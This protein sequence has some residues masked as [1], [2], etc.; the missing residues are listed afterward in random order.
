MALH[1]HNSGINFS[2]R[3]DDYV[4]AWLVSEREDLSRENIFPEVSGY[5]VK[6][7]YASRLANSRWQVN[8]KMPPGLSQG[9]HNLSIR[10]ADS[11]WSNEVRLAVDVPAHAESLHVHRACD[12][13][14]WVDGEVT[15]GHLTLWVKGLPA[16]ADLHNVRIY[17]G[18][19]RLT[20]EYLQATANEE[21]YRQINARLPRT[22]E[23]GPCELVVR[24]GDTAS[25][26]FPMVVQP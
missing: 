18:P 9:W 7:I 24:L 5:G 17:L 26:A 8:F 11:A 6:P 20:P 10:V 14:N 16:N 1:S 2:S 19:A 12:G 15:S 23:P 25:N 4:S 3:A 21:G 13:L 22:A